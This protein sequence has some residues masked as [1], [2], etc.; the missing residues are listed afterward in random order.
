MVLSVVWKVLYLTTSKTVPQCAIDDA[1]SSVKGGSTP[2]CV[3]V[4][5]GV[6][7]VCVGASQLLE[8]LSTERLLSW[9]CGDR[10]KTFQQPSIYLSVSS[11]IHASIHPYL[12]IRSGWEHPLLMQVSGE[13]KGIGDHQLPAVEAGR[14][15]EGQWPDPLH[16][17]IGLWCH[18]QPKGRIV[19]FWD[20]SWNTSKF[21]SP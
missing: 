15:D 21:K 6:M 10:N 8:D 1:P 18:L 12:L 11:D 14:L 5:H 9:T 20:L 17:C 19:M 7:V 2:V 16:H 3:I 13:V 4:W